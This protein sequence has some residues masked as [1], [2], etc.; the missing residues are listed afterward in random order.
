MIVEQIAG[1]GSLQTARGLDM[2]DC[3]SKLVD[4]PVV[5]LAVNQGF[6]RR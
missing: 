4:V 3:W 1:A 5:E 2:S 6:S